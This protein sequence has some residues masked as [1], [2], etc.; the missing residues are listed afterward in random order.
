MMKQ[1]ASGRKRIILFIIG[2]GLGLVIG[3]LLSFWFGDGPVSVV[4]RSMR[5]ISGDDNNPHFDMLA[6]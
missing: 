6:Q 2:A 3:V 4:Q 1:A 5:R